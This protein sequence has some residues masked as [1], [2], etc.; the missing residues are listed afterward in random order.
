M[1]NQKLLFIKYIKSQ[2]E[3]KKKEMVNTKSPIY[4]TIFFKLLCMCNVN[5]CPPLPLF[6]VVGNTVLLPTTYVIAWG[7]IDL[8]WVA[9]NYF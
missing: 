2:K 8:H 1:K 5:I 7:N 3:R 6:F 9:G 4:V